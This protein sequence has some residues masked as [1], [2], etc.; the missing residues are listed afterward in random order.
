MPTYVYRCRKCQQ[1][2]EVVQRFSEAP[3]TIC[4]RCSGALYRLLFPPAIIFK[5]SGWYAT[6]HK[7][8]SGSNGDK[9]GVAT[10]DKAAPAA[11]AD[12]GASG[13]TKDQEPAVAP[14][15]SDP[16]KE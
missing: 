13:S 5:G 10:A 8:P 11:N 1:D 14:K 2:L 12:K 16:G 15:T 4:P 6:D 3:L 9:A 7:S